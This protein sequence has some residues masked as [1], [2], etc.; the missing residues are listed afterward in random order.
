MRRAIK[1][2]LDIV[3][4][5]LGLILLSPLMVVVA[6]LVRWRMGKPVFFRQVRLGRH[7]VPFRVFKFRTMVVGAEKKGSGLYTE[8]DDPRFTSL[9]LLL[10]RYS[11]DEIP[12]LLNVLKGEMSLV[13]PRP[14]VE[15]VVER[16][17]EW[18]AV[19]LKVKP[20][21]TGP[22]QVG[23]RNNIPRSRR[24][25]LDADYAGSWTLR[26]DFKILFKTVLVVCSQRGQQNYAS[27]EDVEK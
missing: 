15:P 20:G 16:Y 19:I 3:V 24:L 26:S 6:L 2:L 7:S 8:N 1:R 11:L 21:I 23:G 12:Q 18:Y 5:L 10:R 22:A 17:R 9:G 4:A 13:G 14:M 27:E 25:Q